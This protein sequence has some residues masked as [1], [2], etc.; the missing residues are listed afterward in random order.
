MH[1]SAVTYQQFNCHDSYIEHTF[2]SS[3]GQCYG[4]GR[5]CKG[6]YANVSEVNV[7]L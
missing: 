2:S 3:G 1:R 4:G 7:S 5:Y 6:V